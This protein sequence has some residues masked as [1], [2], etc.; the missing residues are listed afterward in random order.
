MEIRRF[1][2]ADAEAVAQV[3]ATTTEIKRMAR[4]LTDTLLI[5]YTRDL[6][7]PI[8]VGEQVATM[9]Y[10]PPYSAPIVYSLVASRT[11]EQRENVPK[12]LEEIYNEVDADPNPFPPFSVEL[13]FLLFSPLLLV[14]GIAAAIIVM[15]KKRRSNKFRTPKPAN[16]YVK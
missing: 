16:R 5:E 10:N 14:L 7:A 8:Q 13:A 1:T 6:T 11:V 2:E 9:T 12:T 4:K 3:V 15:R